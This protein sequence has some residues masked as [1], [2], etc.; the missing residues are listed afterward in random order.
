[1]NITIS[2]DSQNWQH[3]RSKLKENGIDSTYGSF[4]IY[5][6]YNSESQKERLIAVMKKLGIEKRK[7]II[8]YIVV[9]DDK[10]YGISKKEN[11]KL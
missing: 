8:N 3:I 7:G 5:P 4:E 10:L 2:C 9:D 6:V 1:M 11:E